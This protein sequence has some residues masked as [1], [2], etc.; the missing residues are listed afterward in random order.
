[1]GEHVLQMTKNWQKILEKYQFMA[2]ISVIL[3]IK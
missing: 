2:K 1:M 3:I